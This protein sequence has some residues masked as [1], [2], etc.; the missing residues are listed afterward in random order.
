MA[1]FPIVRSAPQPGHLLVGWVELLRNPSSAAD[2]FR[3][4]REDGRKRPYELNPSYETRSPGV[5]SRPG[6]PAPTRWRGRAFSSQLPYGCSEA[7]YAAAVSRSSGPRLLTT[8]TMS[9]VQV[10]ARLPCCMS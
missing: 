10:P 3:I 5:V 8:G 9:G 1:S 4:A 6:T 7:R 2:G